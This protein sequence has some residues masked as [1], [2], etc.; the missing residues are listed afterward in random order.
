VSTLDHTVTVLPKTAAFGK[1][2]KL[3]DSLKATV[4]SIDFHPALLYSPPK[5]EQT[6]LEQPSSNNLFAVTRIDL[7][8]DGAKPA[9]PDGEFELENGEMRQTLG[10]S[11]LSAAKLDGGPLSVT[12]LSPG[13]QRSGWVLGEIPRSEA[14][15]M[16]T[17]VYQRDTTRTP[18]E[19]EWTNTPKQGTRDL[20]QFAIES[21]QLPKT[22]QQGQD[23]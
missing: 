6:F 2:F 23:V 19:L 3:S 22:A 7:K 10:N 14:K 17:V 11:P 1:T 21:L 5:S 4:K 15:E 9:A 16:I 12:R 20:P 13:Q 8:N 18:P